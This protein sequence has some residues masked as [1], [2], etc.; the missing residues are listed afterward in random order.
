MG[1]ETIIGF[2]DLD[3]HIALPLGIRPFFFVVYVGYLCESS[4]C[5]LIH[6]FFF[7]SAG[8]YAV[9]LRGRLRI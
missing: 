7:N 3:C 9:G 8:T 6:F 2:T 1:C 4:L 5:V